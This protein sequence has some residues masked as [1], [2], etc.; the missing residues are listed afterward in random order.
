MEFDL[1]EIAKSWI[2]AANP[3]EE[4]SQLAKKRYQICLRCDK[5]R[6]S[7][8]ITHDEYCSA[9]TCPISKKIFSNKFNACPNNYWLSAENEYE[10]ILK[11]ESIKTKN[12]K[13]II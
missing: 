11:K 9:C 13:T 12:K 1:I 7:R 10:S 3:S 4:Q 6:K 8:P 5:Y 2:T